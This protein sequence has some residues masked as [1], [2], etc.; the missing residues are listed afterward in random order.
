M[1]IVCCKN[2]NHLHPTHNAVHIATIFHDGLLVGGG[3]FEKLLQ[4]LAR[5]RELVEIIEGR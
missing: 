4:H 5:L 1:K 2:N 3:A